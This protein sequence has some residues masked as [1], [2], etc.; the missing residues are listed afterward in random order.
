MK[1]TL[2]LL[3]ATLWLSAC[4]SH[5]EGQWPAPNQPLE[6]YA[7]RGKVAVLGP[8]SRDSAN[9]YWQQKAADFKL[10][11]TSFLGTQVLAMEGHP[12]KVSLTNDQGTFEDTDAQYLLFQLT[13][14][15][16]PVDDFPHWLKGQSGERGLVM[17]RDPLGRIQVL[18]S[19]GWT[20]KYSRWTREGGRYLPEVMDMTKDNIKIKLQI[21]QWQ[22]L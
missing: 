16:L 5:P 10:Q 21:H 3:L 14:W 1:K 17:E 13:G 2:L 11:L 19:E 18:Q 15:G 12:G 4:V 8:D 6:R 9:L 22:P 7:V 20:I